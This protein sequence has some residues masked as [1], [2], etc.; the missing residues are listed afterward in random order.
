MPPSASHVSPT[1]AE[2]LFDVVLT[3]VAESFRPLEHRLLSADEIPRIGK[4]LPIAV[5]IF[6]PVTREHSNILQVSTSTPGLQVRG[7]GIAISL[8]GH[9]QTRLLRSGL[10]GPINNRYARWPRRTNEGER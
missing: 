5:R 8:V 4:I 7:M 9:R 3:C 2:H 10:L 1:C 6:R